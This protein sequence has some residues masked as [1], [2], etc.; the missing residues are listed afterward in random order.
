MVDVS[1][2]LIPTPTAQPTLVESA[3]SEFGGIVAVRH[4]P[5]DD[6]LEVTYDKARISL[7]DLSHLIH[8]LGYNPIL[9]EPVHSSL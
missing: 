5:D 8:T 6:L 9:L 3:L 1:F 2:Q 7:E 4:N